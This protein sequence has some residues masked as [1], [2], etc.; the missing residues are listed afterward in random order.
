V[1]SVGGHHFLSRILK[2]QQIEQVG[3]LSVTL[4]VTWHTECLKAFR[5]RFEPIAGGE[6][7]MSDQVKTIVAY[8]LGVSVLL[9]AWSFFKTWEPPLPV[10]GGTVIATPHR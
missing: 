10:G 7:V 8:I 3:P 1:P 6:A 5:R 4:S 2:N 9:L